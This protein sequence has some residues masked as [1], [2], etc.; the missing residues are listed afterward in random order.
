MDSYTCQT[1][2]LILLLKDNLLTRRTIDSVLSSTVDTEVYILENGFNIAGKS[3]LRDS[4]SDLPEVHFF[5]SNIN[6]GFCGGMNHLARMVAEHNPDIKYLLL[7]NDDAYL[8]KHTIEKLLTPIS[9]GNGSISS[10]RI[11]SHE[12]PD[13]IID[14]GARCIPYLFQ[15]R[16]NN[17]KHNV[18]DRP[19][20]QSRVVQFC[21]GT[22][23]MI[24]F[25][26]FQELGGFDEKFFAYFEDWDF[27]LRARAKGHNVI[28]VPNASA[29]HVGSASSGKNS[30]LY[31]FLMTRNRFLIA[32]KHLNPLI[33][34]SFFLPYFVISRVIIKSLLLLIGGERSGLKGIRKAL[35]WI[36]S[37]TSTR[38]KHWPIDNSL[39]H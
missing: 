14:D 25:E 7:L 9:S 16:A 36:S 26:L 5:Q 1:A 4:H 38:N 19:P 33:F 34:F 12:Q 29:W 37:P 22:C 39:P 13:I 3:L 2:V 8:D 27:C 24:H 28:H 15:H 11:L 20:T 23:M 30:P 32:R 31:Q 6:L 18:Y 10:P 35:L 21:A 17:Y